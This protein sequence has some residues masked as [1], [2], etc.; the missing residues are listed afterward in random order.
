MFGSL[1]PIFASMN[2]NEWI[3]ATL[4][5]STCISGSIAVSTVEVH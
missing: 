5:A 2:M 4:I 3:A 1:S